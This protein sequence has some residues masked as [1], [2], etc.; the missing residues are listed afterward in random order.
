M[1]MACRKHVI[2]AVGPVYDDTDEDTIKLKATQLEACYVNGLNLAVEHKIGSIVRLKDPAPP[3][4]PHTNCKSSFVPLIQAFCSISTGIYGYP[5]EDATHIALRTV[6]E[7][8]D[9]GKA[10]S[11]DR[12]IF[13]VWSDEDKG[14]Y[15]YV[16]R[17]Q[18]LIVSNG[19]VIGSSSRNTF[20]LRASRIRSILKR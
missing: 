14:V 2:H 20:L 4:L 11:L 15:E 5:I 16:S 19:G 9:G 6:R 18:R 12:I 8:L 10:E 3:S 1:A 13:C 17:S 7:Y